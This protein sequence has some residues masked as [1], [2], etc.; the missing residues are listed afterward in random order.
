MAEKAPT[1]TDGA[2]QVTE[3]FASIQGESTRAGLP[4]GFIRLAGCNL[5][6]SW[7]DTTYSYEGGTEMTLSA[8][9]EQVRQWGLPLVEITGGEPLLQPLTPVMASL[10]LDRGLTVLIET[11]GSMPIDVLPSEVVRILDIKCPESGMQD[12]MHWPNLEL[13]TTRDEVKF[14]LASQSDYRWALDILRQFDLSRRCGTVLFSPVTG[15][16]DP[17]DLAAWMM[18]DKPTARLQLPLHKYIW[19]ERQRGV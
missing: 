4:C 16:L 1:L 14:V 12:R 8:I 17:K 18:A 9:L 19:P 10:L 3:L 2:L 6:C 5:R 11:N 13:L 15:R 7:C